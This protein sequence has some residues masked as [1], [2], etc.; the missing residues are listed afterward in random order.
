MMDPKRFEIFCHNLYQAFEMKKTL[1][2]VAFLTLFS[3]CSIQKMAGE[4]VIEYTHDQAV[5]YLMAQ[6]DLA[7]ACQMG[8]S[9]GPVLAS[10][11]RVDLQPQNIGI[12]THMAAGMCAEFDQRTAELARLRA[13]HENRTSEAQDALIREKQGHRLAALRMIQAYED[14]MMTFGD[15][16]QQCRHFENT[17]DELL[18]LLGLASG[19]LGLLHEFN[20]EKS[21]GISLEVTSIIEKSASCFDDDKWWGLP[22]ALRAALW[23]SIPGAGPEGVD[24]IQ[25]MQD[26]AKKGDAQ[27]VLLARAMLVMMANSIGKSDIMCQALAEIPD[28]QT[29]NPEYALLNAYATSMMTHQADIAWTKEKGHRAPFMQSQCPA[30]QSEPMLDQSQMDD[31]LDGLL[32]EEETAETPA[33]TQVLPE[34]TP[35]TITETTPAASMAQ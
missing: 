26:A 8:Q 15:M 13:L 2:A 23:L 7:S 18:S 11:S 30:A 28:A 16:S 31:L 5:P 25:A 22:T 34:T 33:Q 21:I 10:F 1:C 6:G 4:A 9:L 19:A 32:D 20:S 14:A 24:P 12:A 27:G 3:G 35:Q 29:L 17:T